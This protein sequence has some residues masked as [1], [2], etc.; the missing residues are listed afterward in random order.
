M[1]SPSDQIKSPSARAW[2]RWAPW[3]I[4]GFA[5]SLRVA[6]V[7]AIRDSALV[8]YPAIDPGAYLAR[9]NEILAGQWFPKGVFFQD[10]LYP[11]FLAAM[12]WATGYSL[13]G[14]Y[15]IH[16]AVSAISCVL[17]YYIGKRSFNIIVGTVAGFI[18]AVYAPFL[19]LDGQ[20]EKNTF[21][22]AALLGAILAFPNESNLKFGRVAAAG[23][24]LGIGALLRGNFLLIAPAWAVLLFFTGSQNLI[25]RVLTVAVFTGFVVLPMLPFTFHNWN[26]SKTFVLTTAQAGTAFY[27]GNNPENVSG[28]VHSLSF[29]RQIPEFEADDW[30]REAERLT[31]RTLTPSE[32]SSFWFGRA[33]E[34]ITKDPGFS[35]WI[36][37]VA[38]KI[39]LIMNRFESPD[40][41]SM[42][43]MERVSVIVRN[44]PVRFAWV[45]PFGLIG[46]F[47]LLR[48]RHRLLLATLVIYLGTI[49]MFPISE[50]YRAPFA[51]FLIL[52]AGVYVYYFIEFIRMRQWGRLAIAAALTA[53]SAIVVNHELRL[54]PEDTNLRLNNTLLKGYHDEANA[55]INNQ[56]WDRAEAV[57][58]D[59]MRDEWF[60]KKARLSIDLAF[61]RWYKYKDAATAKDLLNKSIK[62]M[63]R[64]GISVPDGYMLL[65]LILSAEGDHEQSKYWQARA[66]AF[67]SQQWA[68]SLETAR[69]S[70]LS[71]EIA[72]AMGVFD[73][74]VAADKRNPAK[75]L[76]SDVYIRLA[77]LQLQNQNRTRAVE[78]VKLLIQRG[79]DPPAD[80]RALLPP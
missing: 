69:E 59:A 20:L 30:R 61:V 31:G 34:H 67:N 22:I 55:F 41:S 51:M 62:A 13:L 7:F 74:Y 76:E 15:L 66:D 73:E 60:A 47:A 35:W 11:Y 17:L 64:E 32:V 19:Y 68:L 63:L 8:L 40:N 33:W 9:A 43:Y 4:L 27:I 57:L 52:G 36:G 14:P 24:L 46:I 21:T 16:A 56:Q 37:L 2:A 44:D 80:L 12:K 75:T 45:A 39:E 53:V 49:L 71:G 3:L 38:K 28:G 77:R 1:D 70:E 18:A 54:Q 42:G 72:R 29:N 26:V 79:G 10:P 65:A 5:F 25:K 50:R 58:N 6:H 78:T 48:K 23:F